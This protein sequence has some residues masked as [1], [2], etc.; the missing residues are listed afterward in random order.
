MMNVK[1]LMNLSIILFTSMLFSGCCK[2]TI[3]KPS[4]PDIEVAEVKQCRSASQM[5]NT[6]CVLTNYMNVREERDKLR[7]AIDRITE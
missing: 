6:K 5:E 2:N 4:K 7:L 3:V 1:M